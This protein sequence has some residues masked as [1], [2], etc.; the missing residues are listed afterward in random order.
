MHSRY[1]MKSGKCLWEGAFFFFFL[2]VCEGGI[3]ITFLGGGT[4][5]NLLQRPNIVK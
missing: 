1:I 2:N 4:Y 3:N 5:V